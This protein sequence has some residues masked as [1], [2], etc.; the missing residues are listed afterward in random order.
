MKQ[1]RSGEYIVY[2]LVA[3]VVLCFTVPFL[4]PLGPPPPAPAVAAPALPPMPAVGHQGTL[5]GRPG[6]TVPVA[7][8]AV[9]LVG[10]GSDASILPA[11]RDKYGDNVL[12]VP[13]HTH[14]QVVAQHPDFPRCVQIEVTSGEHKHLQGFVWPEWVH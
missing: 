8:D 14:V 6:W 4:V 2:G 1:D 10:F 11:L 7:L 13:E 12:Y 5:E 9:Y 3:L